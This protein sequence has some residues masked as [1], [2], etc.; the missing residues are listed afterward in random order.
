MFKAMVIKEILLV[1]RDR[2]A[3]AALFIMPAV[4][5][6]IMSIAL[7]DTFSNSRPLLHY[8]I[9]D[10][11]H[12]PAARR[13]AGFL[14]DSGLLVFHDVDI[15]DSATRRQLLHSRLQ[16]ILTIPAGF[17]DALADVDRRTHL[18]RL[19]VAADVQ[20]E[21][22]TV[23]QAR[24]ATDILRLRLAAMADTLAPFAP[25]AAA[26]LRGQRQRATGVADV[27]FSG[28]P[29]GKRP[30][31]TQQS[32][33][34]WIVFGMFFVIIPLSTVFINER[35]QHTLQRMAAMNISIP[36]LFAGKIIPYI[37]I[38]QLQVALM[39]GVGV[40]LVPLFGGTPLTPGHCPVGLGMV[41][42]AL[43][44][45]AIGTALF[46]AVTART[47]E[48]ATTIGGLV[49]ILFGAIG[50][51]MVPKF[52]M[53][54]GMQALAVVSPMSW[55]LDGFLDIFLR[56]LGPKEVALESFALAAFGMTLLV[57]AGMVLA[58]QLKRGM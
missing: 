17:A 25:D 39:I 33:P 32:V 51:V 45:A 40:F 20:Q 47:V 54:E 36:V 53:P 7:K 37:I 26:A 24:L 52:Y 55:G 18:V 49:N 28:T 10:H 50:G 1:L 15:P 14:T 21:A 30:T 48:Q 34:S 44:L 16:L 8:A 5:I 31:S 9:V 57:M 46:I 19:D 6:L 42:L 27:Y 38:N 29:G 56:G 13:L 58:H 3:L 2:H 23:F 22:L 4:F 12:S 35:R 41:S 43:S 11:D